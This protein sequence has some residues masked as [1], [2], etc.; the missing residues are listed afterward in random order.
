MAMVLLSACV[1]PVSRPIPLAASGPV[2]VE[3]DGRSYIADLEPDEAGAVL[4]ISRDNAA[5]GN[6]EGLE[7]KRV[8]AQFCAARGG[9]LPRNGFGHYLG[10]TWV[11]R[12]GCA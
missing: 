9:S 8:A 1:A 2:A 12:G 4:T 10:G 6:F 5:F 7:A 3:R 11:F